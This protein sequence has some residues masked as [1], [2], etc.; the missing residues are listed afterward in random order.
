MRILYVEDNFADAD[1][2]RRHLARYAPSIQ[3]EIATSY[4]EAVAQLEKSAEQHGLY[5]LVLT[6]VR[7][8]DGDGLRLLGH[9]RSRRLELPVV[10]L[11]GSGNEEMA[12]AALKGGA[13]DYLSKR[14]GY[15]ARLPAVLETALQRFHAASSHRRR[16]LNVLYA[17]HTP[18][19]IDLTRRFLARYAP[20]IQL[21]VVNTGPEVIQVFVNSDAGTGYDLLL[22]DYRL[23]GMNALDVVKEL[24]LAG[25][26]KIPV[27]LV[28]GQG[29]EEVAVQALRL[30]ISDYLVKNPGYL[31]QLPRTLENTYNQRQL[32]LERAAL[33]ESEQRYRMLFERAP[34]IISTKDAEGRYTSINA[35]GVGVIGQNPIGLTDQ[36]LFPAEY[37][38]DY[39]AH[40]QD[41]MHTR[42][43]K[44]R[45]ERIPT[46]E[47]ERVFLVR[48][49]PLIDSDGGVS[50][51]FGISLDITER[52]RAEEDRREHE[53]RF[54][55]L[56]AHIDQVFWLLET[57]TDR[58]L[59]ISPAYE[60]MWGR[61]CDSAYADPSSIA[62]AILPEERSRFVEAQA[63]TLHGHAAEVEVRVQRP[64]GTLV[65]VVCQ[66][67]PVFDDTGGIHRIAGT[68][69]D[70]TDRRR[71]QEHLQQ[72]ERLVTVGQMAAGIAHDFNYILAVI[73]LYTQ[74]LQLTVQS[75]VQQRHLNTIYQQAK[76]AANLVEQILDFSRRSTLERV[77]MD[78]CPF[79]K[80]MVKLWQRTLPENVAIRLITPEEPLVVSADP[81]RLQQALTNI[82]INAR[83]A[84]SGGGELILSLNALTVADEDDAPL[85]E[86]PPG[87][88]VAIT[89]ADS[90]VGIPPE[91]IPRI[92]DP[93]FTTKPPGQGTGLGLAQVFGIVRQLDG[94]I[95]VESQVGQGA[96]FT[97]YLPML[98]RPDTVETVTELAPPRG[99]GETIL[100]V[101]DEKA[102][103]T[104]MY[105]ML[106]TLGY[107]VLTAENGRRARELFTAYHHQIALLI[108]DLVMPD[109]SGLELHAQLQQEPLNGVPL[110]LLLVTGYPLKDD[111]KQTIEH[112]LVDWIQ[113]PFTMDTLAH[114]VALALS[115]RHPAAD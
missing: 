60:T 7:L 77:T 39:R 85:P 84:M 115:S 114:R 96:R 108:S 42:T 8:P 15:L 30:G 102:L 110:R 37:V 6:D 57:A 97:L 71:E 41:V 33:Q 111:D 78:L 92:F 18:A 25:K 68:A 79:V 61:S 91:I 46:P 13:D 89:I 74:M 62:Q 20:D 29:D 40:D 70:V 28:T 14:D 34:V 66:L 55:Q 83:D 72:Q 82:A 21:D 54:G 95:Q 45:Q 63:R 98:D 47:G 67:F 10:V 107:E 75:A 100:L 58:L 50:G 101:E 90:G 93:F 23:P 36:Q 106:S 4:G 24:E 38:A 87:R 31:F 16:P 56:V 12:V 49:T 11:T 2:A 48:K 99:A 44:M 9:I 94:Q 69:R 109:M 22:L 65:W 80:E 26:L 112:G 88:W 53:Q 5:D 43:E 64:D 104:A 32:Q 113:K 35:L 103:R 51:V 86:M 73:M 52:I 3:M 59:F 1:L 19:D 27:V 76:H 105:E 81:A 17:E